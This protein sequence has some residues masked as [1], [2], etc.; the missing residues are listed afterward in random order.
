MKFFTRKRLLV[1][2]LISIIISMLLVLPMIFEMLGFNSFGMPGQN[3]GIKP[4]V[5]MNRFQGLIKTSI[6]FIFLVFVLL[7]VYTYD[8]R[9]F[10]WP[11]K[12]ITSIVITTAAYLFLPLVRHMYP[13]PG[14]GAIAPFIPAFSG[15]DGFMPPP[16]GVFGDLLNLRRIIEFAFVLATTGL[17]GKI[18]EL[19]EQKEQIK[20]ENEK[21]RAEN[22]QS[23]YDLLLKQ[24]NPHFFF[25]SMNSL[26]TLVREGRKEPAL[27]YI[28]E[29][30]NTFRYVMQSSSKELVTL[31]EEISSLSAYCYMLLVRYEGKL[32]FNIEVEEALMKMYLPVLSL[33]PLIENVVKHNAITLKNPLTVNVTGRND[34]FLIVTN[35]IIPRQEKSDPTGI[36]LKNLATRYKLLSG[37]HI[38]IEDDGQVFTVR[39]PLL[40]NLKNESTDNRG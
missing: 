30:S 25:N 10:S 33:Q 16:D 37:E 15:N 11:K 19:L 31:E 24:M 20:V 9:R 34:G 17:I 13:Y 32:F 1:I 39:L 8:S 26:S 7:T 38:T 3:R 27:R 29:L 5:D 6:Y 2:L 22:L 4:E 28:G 36:G 21:L 12:I 40:K 14:P 35:R 23:Q 18:F